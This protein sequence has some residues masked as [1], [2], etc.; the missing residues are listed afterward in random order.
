[1]RALLL[2]RFS[3]R[4]QG[5]YQ[6]VQFDII[7]K[8]VGEEGAVEAAGGGDDEVEDS[9]RHVRALAAA[10]NVPAAAELA[11]YTDAGVAGDARPVA[12]EFCRQRDAAGAVFLSGDFGGGKVPRPLPA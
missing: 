5:G 3:F 10:G 9:R 1:M 4:I 12:G 8:M 2:C 6:L 11:I 7:F